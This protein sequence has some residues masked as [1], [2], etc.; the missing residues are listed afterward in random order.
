MTQLYNHQ[1][2]SLYPEKTQEAS[3]GNKSINWQPLK[4][5]ITDQNTETPVHMY[6]KCTLGD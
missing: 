1:Q 3:A 5:T 2:D 6:R 4:R